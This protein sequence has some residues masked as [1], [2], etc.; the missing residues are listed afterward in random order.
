MSGKTNR[1]VTT[2]TLSR[3][4]AVIL[5]TYF[6]EKNARWDS[7]VR[8]LVSVDLRLIRNIQ[9]VGNGARDWIGIRIRK[10]VQVRCVRSQVQHRERADRTQEHTHGAGAVHTHTAP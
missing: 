3:S 8:I 6:F 10:E 5:T 4:K 7:G 2:P 1:I 9:I